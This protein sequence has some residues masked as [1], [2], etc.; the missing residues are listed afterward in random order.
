[1]L[2]PPTALT[3]AFS[4]PPNLPVSTILGWRYIPQRPGSRKFSLAPMEWFSRETP[5]LTDL[6]PDALL[7][8][9]TRI[10]Q[11]L[12]PLVEKAASEGYQS[13]QHP[14]HTAVYLP[15]W[16]SRVW[17]DADRLI[18]LRETWKGRLLWAE[19]TAAKEKWPTTLLMDA[20]TTIQSAPWMAGYN[21]LQRGMVSVVHLARILLSHKWLDD[22]VIDC[23]RDTLRIEQSFSNSTALPNAG[24]AAPKGTTQR[25]P[26]ITV[27]SAHLR[28]CLLSGNSGLRRFYSDKLVSGEVLKLLLPCNL[29]NL[30]WV[31]AEID[32]AQGHIN[33]GDSKPQMSREHINELL[34]DLRTWL[35]EILP[36]RTWQ[37]NMTALETGLQQDSSSCGL[38][39]INAIERRISSHASKWTPSTPGKTRV[40]YFIRCVRAGKVL[41]THA[42][43]T[44]SSSDEPVT[45]EASGQVGDTYN[46]D[47][48]MIEHVQSAPLTS[49]PE[50]YDSSEDGSSIA[51]EQS[52]TDTG[53]K[54]RTKSSQALRAVTVPKNRAVI[55]QAQKPLFATSQIPVKL[56]ITV[57]IVELRHPC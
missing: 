36:A 52:D 51:S 48:S 39:T 3:E 28:T 11:S 8:P 54:P 43:T 44:G 45:H 30:H 15:L 24:P 55:M 50:S 57:R 13:I 37:T 42:C 9:S 31:P 56:R 14:V 12:L 40:R 49:E 23:L 18:R 4:P 17:R 26:V 34:R 33:L 29:R 19:T 41:E 38:A 20:L 21:G 35:Q 1:M 27:A 7:L 16:I 22:E 32:V 25:A 53:S 46:A 2:N 47:S 5:T 6:Q 10:C